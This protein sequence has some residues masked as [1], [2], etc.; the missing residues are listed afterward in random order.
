MND[1]DENRADLLTDH[2]RINC[3]RRARERLE[4]LS[5][6]IA[7]AFADV[8]EEDGL[9]EIEAATAAERRHQKCG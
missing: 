2:E 4:A 8:P 3:D 1:K 9:A 7:A 5:S 6:Q